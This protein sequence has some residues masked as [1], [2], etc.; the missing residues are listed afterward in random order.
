MYYRQLWE[1]ADL[2]WDVA[3]NPDFGIAWVSRLNL[4]SQSFLGKSI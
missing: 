1:V 2:R 3:K 4:L